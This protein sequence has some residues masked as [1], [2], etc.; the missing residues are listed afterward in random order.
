MKSSD[1][2]M[3]GA[4]SRTWTEHSNEEGKKWET[5][6]PRRREGLFLFLA[7]NQIQYHGED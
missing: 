4:Q 7:G 3:K 5:D 1:K 2:T 6:V